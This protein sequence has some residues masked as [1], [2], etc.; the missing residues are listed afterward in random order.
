MNKAI[1]INGGDSEFWYECSNNKCNSFYN[2]YK[3]QAHQESF[4]TDPHL[5][6]GNFG[7]YGSGKTLTSR[8]QFYKHMFISPGGNT[9]IG[10]NVTS[11]YEMTIKRDIEAD[12]PGSFVKYISNQKQYIDFQNGHR[13][14]FRPFDDVNKLRSYNIDMF[15]I[16]EASEV[17]PAAFE[18]LKTRLRNL[19]ATVPKLDSN[20]VPMFTVAKNG[21]HIPVLQADWR[22]G[23]VESNPDSGWI[24]EEVLLYSDEI[25]K[26]GRILDDYI[27]MDKEKD[28]AI[29]THVTSTEA[30]EFLP[31]NFIDTITKNKPAWWVRR[32]VYGSFNYAEG[33]VYPN[34]QTC[35]VPRREIPRSWKRIISYDYGL[36][37]DSVFLFS[38]IDEANKKVVMYKEV[39]T[40]NKS[41]EQLAKIFHEE[42]KD[43][44]F[45]GM[46][47]PP[48]IDPK[49]APKRDYDKKTLA[50]HFLDYGISFIPGAINIDARVFRLNTYIEAG[51]L[52]IMDCCE[53]LIGE[54]RKYKFKAGTLE[55]S[56][57]S[58]K[59]EDKDNHGINALEWI[60]MEL[61]A[62]PSKLI[63]GIY[64]KMGKDVTI[65]TDIEAQYYIH[66]LSEDD[67]T[68]YHEDAATPFGTINYSYN[69]G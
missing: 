51:Y 46:V 7:G 56:G 38:A 13:V 18:Q 66:A 47:C 68:A 6:K 32:F 50:D 14:M 60:T 48:I 54:I 52:E 5:I 35:I 2:S 63:Y 30:N 40:N 24:R 37:D 1:A 42:T 8:Q 9:V 53:G 4:H 43:I 61:P 69:G 17:K 49:S 3:P 57:W 27:I 62:D 22:T 67:F 33:L 31:K 44:P 36:S 10:A 28:V 55:S 39:R 59:P 65:E 15:I 11:Q 58:N 64:N 34:A 45:G 12:L 26:H 25:H 20:G 41:V 21:V 19:S 29:S 23:I 16:L